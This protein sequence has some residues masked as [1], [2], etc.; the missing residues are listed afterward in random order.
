MRG[1][2]EKNRVIVFLS[3]SKF[4]PFAPHVLT[5]IYY[6][7]DESNKQHLKIAMPDPLFKTL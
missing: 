3:T 5:E 1:L 2:N 7:V 6:E 4:Q